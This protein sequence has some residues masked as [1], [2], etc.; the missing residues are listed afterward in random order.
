MSLLLRLGSTITTPSQY[1]TL[2]VVQELTFRN[3]HTSDITVAR[4]QYFAVAENRRTSRAFARRLNTVQFSNS[5]SVTCHKG[6]WRAEIWASSHVTE[7]T[8]EG[9]N[10]TH[11]LIRQLYLGFGCE[12]TTPDENFS[13]SQA[14]WQGDETKISSGVSQSPRG[15]ESFE[16]VQYQTHSGQNDAGRCVRHT[17]IR[18]TEIQ[19]ISPFLWFLSDLVEFL[20]NYDR[21][22][23]Y[24]HIEIKYRK[25]KCMMQKSSINQQ[26]L[27]SWIVSM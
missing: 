2:K 23:I 17:N 1:D 9:Q 19:Q 21:I 11:L 25:I 8:D 27:A 5:S 6:I 16:I 4:C 26:L 14:L 18:C 15:D 24:W 13:L 7:P 10:V 22:H 12:I 3:Q 20:Y